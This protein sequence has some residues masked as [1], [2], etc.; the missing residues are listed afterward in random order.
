M[1]LAILVTAQ[2]AGTARAGGLTVPGVAAVASRV[3]LALM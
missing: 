2:A 3:L 1:L